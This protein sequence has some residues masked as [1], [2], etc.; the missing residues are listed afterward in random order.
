MLT[1]LVRAVAIRFGAVQAPRSRDVHVEP[2][3]RLGGL[4][5]YFAFA[6]ALLTAAL[7]VHFVFGKPLAPRAVRAGLGLL[8]SGTLLSL[9]G[10]WDDLREI[11]AGQA[12]GA[13][14]PLR[15]LALPFGVRI[16]VLT[17]PFAGG[18]M[19][20]LGWLSY[21]LTVF[22]LVGVTNAVNWVDGIDGLAAGVCAIAA[23]TLALMAVQSRQPALAILAAALFGSLLGFLRYNFNPAKIFMGGGA[24]FVGFT[25]ACDLDGGRLQGRR[26]DGDRGADPDPGPA[27][28]RHRAG[29]LPPLAAGQA[30]LPGGQEPPAPPAAGARLHAAPD[31]ADPLR[32][33]PT[34][35][36]G[37]LRFL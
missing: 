10:V 27:D 22:W 15:A 12:D 19:I 17:N 35:W 28:L 6:I 34:L 30:D 29:D 14:D 21:P 31:R 2:V 25:L 8:A 32:H 1:P 26:R 7:C 36:H 4:A 13:P 24:L 16:E 37:V 3:P 20:Y 23:M 5:I 9:L 33:Q 18:Q 11:S